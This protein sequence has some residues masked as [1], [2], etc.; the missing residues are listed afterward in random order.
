ME[1]NEVIDMIND[2]RGLLNKCGCTDLMITW[3]VDNLEFWFEPDAY[4]DVTVED[5]ARLI[6]IG[7]AWHQGRHDI[8]RAATADKPMDWPMWAGLR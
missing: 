1:L 5:L 8:V 4:Q 3:F 7:N 2:S 6:L